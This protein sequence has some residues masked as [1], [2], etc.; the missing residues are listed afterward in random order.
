[1]QTP[2]KSVL[3]IQKQIAWVREGAGIITSVCSV[4]YG[5]TGALRHIISFHLHLISSPSILSC[6]DYF[7]SLTAI[8]ANSLHGYLLPAGSEGYGRRGLQLQPFGNFQFRFTK[9]LC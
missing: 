4:L 6:K 5:F 3:A 7:P 2:L 9:V 8:S 1:M